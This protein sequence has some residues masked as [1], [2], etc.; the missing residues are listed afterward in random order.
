MNE[1]IGT[2]LDGVLASNTHDVKD[3]RPWRLHQ[4]YSLCE[5]TERCEK[6]YDVILTGRRIHFKKITIKWLK[7]NNVTYDILI[8]FPNKVKK[9]NKT[10]AKYKSEVINN[11]KIDV[12]FE[13]DERIFGFLTDACP[14][15]IIHLIGFD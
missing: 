11:L 3:Y 4:W 15:T 12:Y 14:D 1:K 7:E 13:D 2:D 10:L 9:T 5:P 8:M 6:H